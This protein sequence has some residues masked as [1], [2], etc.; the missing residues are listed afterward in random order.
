ALAG[1]YSTPSMITRAM[2]RSAPQP[3]PFIPNMQNQ[4]TLD[5][6]RLSLTEVVSA[7][8]QAA[9]GSQH[10]RHQRLSAATIAPVGR[11]QRSRHP[12]L[13]HCHAPS[14]VV[15]VPLVAPRP[16]RARTQ[17]R[18]RGPACWGAA[19]AL[20]RI[21]CREGFEPPRPKDLV[22]SQGSQPLLNRHK[23]PRGRRL[24]WSPPSLRGLT[25]QHR[26]VDP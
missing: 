13:V 12:S 3:Y 16:W 17:P 20:P 24:R 25:Q 22:Y 1:T 15:V 6:R 23:G 19:A 18:A 11:V 9:T 10:D 5:Q 8:V 2:T 26:R 4:P 7:P 21:V 14:P